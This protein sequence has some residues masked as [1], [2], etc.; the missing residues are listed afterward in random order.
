MPHELA[1]VHPHSR[2]C[3]SVRGPRAERRPPGR[4]SYHSPRSR[5]GYLERGRLASFASPDHD[6]PCHVSSYPPDSDFPCR[7]YAIH[8]MLNHS[9]SAQSCDAPFPTHPAHLRQTCKVAVSR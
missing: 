5:A 4:L 7:D 6:D 3:C 1:H 9:T 8:D 2:P